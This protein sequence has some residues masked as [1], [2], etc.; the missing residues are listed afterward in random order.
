M[1][2]SFEVRAARFEKIDKRLR[3][4]SLDHA[5]SNDNVGAMLATFIGRERRDAEAHRPAVILGSG[6]DDQSRYKG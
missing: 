4:L 1:R 5:I 3:G 2:R 6:R